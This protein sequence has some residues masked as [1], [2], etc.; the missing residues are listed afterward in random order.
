[1]GK[2]QVPR[3]KTV[4]YG[5][6]FFPPASRGCSVWVYY[7]AQQRR[8][9]SHC[10]PPSSLFFSIQEGSVCRGWGGG[11]TKPGPCNQLC[12]KLAL[13]PTHN[14]GQRLGGWW[15]SWESRQHSCDQCQHSSRQYGVTLA[16]LQPASRLISHHSHKRGEQTKPL[17]ALPSLP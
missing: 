15:L 4:G 10:H 13:C 1:M 11:V 5:L 7:A 2:N 16:L 17:S 3:R 6:S 9:S 8:N 14:A 12:V